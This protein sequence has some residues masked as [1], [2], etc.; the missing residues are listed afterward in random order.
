MPEFAARYR[1]FTRAV[2]D[3]LV[4]DDVVPVHLTSSAAY[5]EVAAFLTDHPAPDGVVAASDVIAMSAMQALAERG[6]RVP[7][8]VS[9]VGF[10]DVP[11]ARL[12]TPA[13]TTIPR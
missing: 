2:A 6:L 13:L 3:G 7:E 5:Q 10:D 12:T 1:G 4:Q 9:V 11:L 8:D